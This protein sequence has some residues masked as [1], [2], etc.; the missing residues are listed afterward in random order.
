MS[1]RRRS[2]AMDA[3]LRPVLIAKI[4][5]SVWSFLWINSAGPSGAQGRRRDLLWRAFN[6]AGG[7]VEH[8]DLVHQGDALGLAAG[9][10]QRHGKAGVAGQVATIGDGRDQHVAASLFNSFVVRTSARSVP[11]CAWPMAGSSGTVTMSP[12]SKIAIREPRRPR[13]SPHPTA[14]SRPAAA[15]SG[16]TA[17]SCRPG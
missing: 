3:D 10:G 17:R 16:R 12:R 15:P 6:L 11:R 1:A 7:R 5:L 13:T 9:S 2:S 8:A 4:L 14:P